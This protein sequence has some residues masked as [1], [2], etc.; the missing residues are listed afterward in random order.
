MGGL[1]NCFNHLSF[2][3]CNHQAVGKCRL[4]E[5]WPWDVDLNTLW[6]CNETDYIK[7]V[8]TLGSP[9]YFGCSYTR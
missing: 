8:E 2:F 6:L 5:T 1:C 9:A 7:A 4:E 3:L